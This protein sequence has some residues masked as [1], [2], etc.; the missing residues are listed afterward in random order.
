MNWLMGRNHVP[1]DF[2]II[3]EARILQIGRRFIELRA[4][5]DTTYATA[6]TRDPR[7]K[8]TCNAEKL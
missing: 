1:K 8:V 4:F 3:L 7:V 5:K 2:E 6:E